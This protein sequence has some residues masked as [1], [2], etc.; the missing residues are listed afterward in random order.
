MHLERF[1]VIHSLPEDAIIQMIVQLLRDVGDEWDEE[2]RSQGEVEVPGALMLPAAPPRPPT[3]PLSHSL[4]PLSPFSSFY[5]PYLPSRPPSTPPIWTLSPPCLGTPY[6]PWLLLSCFSGS[7]P[8][9][10]RSGTWP[11][12]SHAPYNSKALSERWLHKTQPQPSG[13]NP[14][15]ESLTSGDPPLIRSMAPRS[16]GERALQMLPAQSPGRPRGPAFCTCALGAIGPPSPAAL[17]S[18]LTVT[19]ATLRLPP[20][21]EASPGLELAMK[22]SQ[23]S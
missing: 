12:F 11:S 3:P 15:R 22:S 1:T 8:L 5:L 23:L 14:R 17:V 2:V 10:S 9:S 7:S 6:S 19:I 21:P 4:L 13:R 18:R 16:P 20:G